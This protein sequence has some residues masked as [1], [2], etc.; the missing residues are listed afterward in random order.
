MINLFF[1]VHDFSGARTYINVLS[2]YLSLKNIN[3]FQVFLEPI[4]IKEFEIIKRG[5]IT[6]VN[7]PRKICKE[8]NKEY[9]KRAAQLIYKNFRSV[10]NVI[11]HA[12]APEQFYFTMEAKRLF[13]CPVVFTFHF[14]EGF[15]SY[16]DKTK[17]YNPEYTMIG[18]ALPGMMLKIANM[19]ICVT[20][21][22]KRAVENYYKINSSKVSVIYNGIHE[23]NIDTN[24]YS[25]TELKLKYGF[26]DEDRILLYAGPLEERK[27]IDVLIKAFHL[28]KD[29]YQ[30]TKLMIIGSGDYDEYLPLVKDCV[31]R[32][33]FAGKVDKQTLESFYLMADIGILSSIYE[34]CSYVVIEMKYHGLPIIVSDTPGLNELVSNNK[35]GL[36]CKTYPD[37]K[38]KYLLKVD[39][40]NLAVKI[41]T[42]LNDEALSNRL[43]QK[44]LLETKERF[45]ISS[46]GEKTF[47]VYRKFVM[48]KSIKNEQ[49]IG[50][51]PYT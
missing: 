48:N 10:K 25:K 47:E 41:K 28:L 31:G 43:A 2:S 33:H 22:A 14:L 49:I 32:I 27:G 20:Q 39:S 7:I 21:F 38:G 12:N 17:S 51:N 23:R 37:S 40:N 36:L 35:T 1:I 45:S 4:N 26:R 24:H 29:D 30:N 3:I 5:N 50:V 46:M 15:L 6:L 13:R 11:F 34:Q 8:Y 16:L 19:N 18:N 9:Y 42:L 44:G